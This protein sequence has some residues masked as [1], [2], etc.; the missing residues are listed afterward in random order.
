MASNF[1]I[2]DGKCIEE[3][4]TRAEMKTRRV[5]QS[6]GKMFSKSGRMK[7]LP[8]NFRRVREPYS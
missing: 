8:S 3:L 1:K 2:F 4:R 7:E 6:T 5:A